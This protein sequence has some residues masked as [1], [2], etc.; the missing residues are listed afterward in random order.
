M[1]SHWLKSYLY[2]HRVTY[3]HDTV[4]IILLRGGAGSLVISAGF[5][6][7]TRLVLT[8]IDLF[9]LYTSCRLLNFPA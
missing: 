7:V 6:F 3:Q 4:R 8:L 2:Q 1:W 5:M 9:F